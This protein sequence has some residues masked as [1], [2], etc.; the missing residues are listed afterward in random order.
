[1][2]AI[3]LDIDSKSTR[4]VQRKLAR[5]P[6]KVADARAFSLAWD[7]RIR[8]VRGLARVEARRERAIAERAS[9]LAAQ[10]EGVVLLIVDAPREAGVAA[11]LAKGAASG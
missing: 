5:K 11:A 4:R 1:M 3:T 7:A 6:P 10:V 2:S 8:K 9:A